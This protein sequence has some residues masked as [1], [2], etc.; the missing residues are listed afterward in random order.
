M[1]SI[2][3]ITRKTLLNEVAGIS[4]IVRKWAD[5]LEKEVKEQMAAHRETEM[6]KIQSEPKEKP[7]KPQTS[8]DFPEDDKKNDPFYWEDE[9]G[10]GSG[11]KY[12]R[13]DDY[14]SSWKKDK[15]Y[16]DWK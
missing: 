1:N 8:F 5:I 14:F 3:K 6:K 13:D 10:Y 16:S 2:R 7:K 15:R 11:S 4:F 12:K 9:S